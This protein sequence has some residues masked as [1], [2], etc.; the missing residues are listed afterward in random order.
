MYRMYIS[1]WSIVSVCCTYVTIQYDSLILQQN[2]IYTHN[3][4]VGCITWS[5]LLTS[6]TSYTTHSNIHLCVKSILDQNFLIEHTAANRH[7]DPHTC[8]IS[9]YIAADQIWLQWC[10]LCPKIC[11]KVIILHCHYFLWRKVL[12]QIIVKIQS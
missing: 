2:F 11:I 5:Q 1:I 10:C 9:F 6:T 4:W 7:S 8:G 3:I 12:K